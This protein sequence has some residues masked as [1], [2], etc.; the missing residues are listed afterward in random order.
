MDKGVSLPFFRLRLLSAIG[1]N[2]RGLQRSAGRRR[3]TAVLALLLALVLGGCGLT[4]PRSSPGF[5]DLDSLGLADT[6][7]V[8]T[9]S[10]GPAVLNFAARHVEEDPETRALLESLDGV[11]I[12]IYEIDGDAERVA[13]RLDGMGRKLENAGWERVLLVREEREQAH[14]L[15]KLEGDRVSGMTVLVS[16]G[17]QEAVVI[18]LMG[19]I[20]PQQF[21]GVMAALEVDAAGVA[22]IEPSEPADDD[23]Q[24]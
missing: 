23:Q 16:D 13:A 9:L 4:A 15:L 1:I 14:M 3:G 2:R 20:Q 11:R 24:S 7:L 17:H 6:D 5:A 8:L 10:I 22:D 21:G 18:N 19:D 12:R